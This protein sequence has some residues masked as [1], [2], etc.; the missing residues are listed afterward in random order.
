MAGFSPN[1]IQPPDPTVGFDK[2][3]EE[4]CSRAEMEI[5]ARITDNEKIGRLQER[6]PS[7]W[8]FRLISRALCHDVSISRKA[9]TDDPWILM[10]GIFAFCEV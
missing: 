6:L 9:S 8:E 2:V 10:S 1:A 7:V 4:G 3:L 5:R